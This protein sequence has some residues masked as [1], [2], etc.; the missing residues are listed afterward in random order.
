MSSIITKNLS[1]TLQSSVD[2]TSLLSASTGV[3]G[4]DGNATVT[5]EFAGDS[6]SEMQFSPQLID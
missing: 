4:G 2:A 1:G 5:D 6:D 3:T